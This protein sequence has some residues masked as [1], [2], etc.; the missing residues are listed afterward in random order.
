MYYQCIILY[1]LNYWYNKLKDV[2]CN[3]FDCYV[4]N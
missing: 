2:W 3:A 1:Y 4:I